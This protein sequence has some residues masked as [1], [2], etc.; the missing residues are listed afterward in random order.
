[1]DVEPGRSSIAQP[2]ESTSTGSLFARF[3][4]FVR[5]EL[6][7][8]WSARVEMGAGIRCVRNAADSPLRTSDYACGTTVIDGGRPVSRHPDPFWR[9]FRCARTPR[10]PPLRRP[11]RRVPTRAVAPAALRRPSVSS[12]TSISPA[13]SRREGTV[14]SRACVSSPSRPGGRT[15]RATGTARARRP[16]QRLRTRVRG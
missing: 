10:L 7:S 14:R 15:R 3:H 2:L 11:R 8:D 16:S 12:A 1:M 6:V 13:P 5:F 4:V 9:P